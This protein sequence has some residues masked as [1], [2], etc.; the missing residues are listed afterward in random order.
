MGARPTA[1]H[2]L[3]VGRVVVV[4]GPQ[5]TKDQELV[6]TIAAQSVSR[7]REAVA[8]EWEVIAPALAILDI[9]VTA[10]VSV[11]G[12]VLAAQCDWDARGQ[13]LAP[14]TDTGSVKMVDNEDSVQ[15]TV[16]EDLEQV[17]ACRVSFAL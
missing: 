5:A 11:P 1:W 12:L 6:G 7:Y 14:V 9:I 3:E 16:S 15:V 4:R 17:V 2:E 8:L 10:L 13:V